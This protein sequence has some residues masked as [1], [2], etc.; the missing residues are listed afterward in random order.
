M[1]KQI[2]TPL[3][4]IVMI[5]CALATTACPKDCESNGDCKNLKADC[6]GEKL[7]CADNRCVCKTC[8][9]EGNQA[10]DEGLCTHLKTPQEWYCQSKAPKC[11][12]AMDCPDEPPAGYDGENWKCEAGR[13]LYGDL[14][15]PK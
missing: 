13:C 5:L 15:Y 8:D 9:P 1:A 10:C 14:E 6:Y 12:D 2:Q 11:E 4:S 3:A 7:T